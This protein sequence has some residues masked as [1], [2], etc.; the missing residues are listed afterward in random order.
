MEVPRRIVLCLPE[1]MPRTDPAPE[2]TAKRDVG[3]AF[4]WDGS[5][6]GVAGFAEA[7]GR[8]SSLRRRTPT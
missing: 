2:E 1:G 6:L 4:D 7:A 5:A 8:R 3:L